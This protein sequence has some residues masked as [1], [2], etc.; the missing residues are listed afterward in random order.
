MAAENVTTTGTGKPS[1]EAMDSEL[2]FWT[3]RL[4]IEILRGSDHL[5]VDSRIQLDRHMPLNRRKRKIRKPRGQGKESE[6]EMN[7]QLCPR[8]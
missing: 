3:P 6:R 7:E 4:T 2:T 8:S 5:A 1:F